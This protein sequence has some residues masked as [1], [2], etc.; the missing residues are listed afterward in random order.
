MLGRCSSATRVQADVWQWYEEPSAYGQGI[1][2]P[3]GSRGHNSAF[4]LPHLSAVQLLSG[5]PP[6]LPAGRTPVVYHVPAPPGGSGQVI[7]WRLAVLW[8]LV[9]VPAKRCP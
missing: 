7:A 2:L 3:S 8:L 1:Q 4:Y 9:D 6:S 5:S